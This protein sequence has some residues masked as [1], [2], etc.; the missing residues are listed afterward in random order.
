[1]AYSSIAQAVRLNVVF[2]GDL[3][4]LPAGDLPRICHEPPRIGQESGELDT[5]HQELA[6]M[7]RALWEEIRVDLGE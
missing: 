3:T 7:F 4:A 5:L 6:R 1:M 2:A